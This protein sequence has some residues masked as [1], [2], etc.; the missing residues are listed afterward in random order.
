MRTDNLF[1]SESTCRSE[2]LGNADV[3]KKRRPRC[4]SQSK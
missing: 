4:S 1:A 2:E 3:E